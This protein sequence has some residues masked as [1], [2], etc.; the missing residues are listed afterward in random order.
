MSGGFDD[1]KTT[2]AIPQRLPLLQE[3]IKNL[4]ADIIGLIDTFRWDEIYTEAQLKE[5]FGYKYA[6]CI[7]LNDERLKQLGHNNG[8]TILSNLEMRPYTVRLDTRDAIVARI[9]GVSTTFNL[10]IAYLDDISEN[11]RLKQVQTLHSLVDFAEPLVLM[12]DLNS[13]RDTERTQ[14]EA[15]FGEF[16]KQNPEIGKKFQPIVNDMLRAETIKQLEVWG[17]RDA[18]QQ[19][20]LPTMPTTLFP[21][22][23]DAPFLRIDFCFYSPS[24]SVSEFNVPY[25]EIF[26]KASDHFPIVFDVK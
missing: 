3:A 19:R 23:V 15:A 6:Y 2:S 12:G 25:D 20:H 18:G 26:Q 22:K 16:M 14:V 10:V 11:A 7:N 21:V 9:Q 8:L 17:L 13:I 4:D 5:L 24:L 1:Y